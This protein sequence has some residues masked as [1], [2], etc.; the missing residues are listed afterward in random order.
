MTKG[1]IER[2]E[3]DENQVVNIGDNLPVSMKI[4]QSIYNEIT[5]KTERLSQTLRNNHDITFNDLK[6]LNIKIRQL[7]E[8]YNVVSKNCAVTVFHVN[9]CKEQFSSFERFEIYDSS[10][11]SPCENVRLEYNFLIVLPGTQKA[12]PYKRNCSPAPY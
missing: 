3:S 10:N 5:G 6:Q 8:Q 7:Y 11:T 9:D 1:I 2:N 12:Q 4:V